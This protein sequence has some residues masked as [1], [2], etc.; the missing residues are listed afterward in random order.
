MI[1][2]VRNPQAQADG[3]DKLSRAESTNLITLK[4]DCASRTDAAQAI[5]ELQYSHSISHIDVVVANAAIA[6]HYGPTSTLPLQVLEEHMQVNCYSVLTLFHA[7]RPLLQNAAPGQAKVVFIGAPI[8]T[9]THMEDC[10]R[11]PLGSYG[12]TKLAANYLVRKFHFENNW[13]MAFVID[14][15]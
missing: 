12:L 15:G 6:N 5:E 7:T 8:S 9:I 2:C 10:A 14:P 4:L 11:A 1:A 3:L 13:L